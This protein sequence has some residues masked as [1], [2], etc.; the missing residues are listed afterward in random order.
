M[1]KAAPLALAWQLQL[2]LL[3]A[4]RR[5][6]WQ[7]AICR[8]T[9]YL[10]NGG[11]EN[12]SLGAGAE[13]ES[14]GGKNARRVRLL[15]LSACVAVCVA[16]TYLVGLYGLEASASEGKTFVG[17]IWHDATN[18]WPGPSAPRGDDSRTVASRT[19]HDASAP[20]SR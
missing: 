12:K 13:G 14:R 3:S 11:V 16:L 8:E 19:T 2:N 6:K 17:L 20:Q 10:R 15:A 1:R 18:W 5:P 4:A 9:T 7:A